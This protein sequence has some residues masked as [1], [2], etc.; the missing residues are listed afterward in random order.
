MC[1]RE[2]FILYYY[3]IENHAEIV[4]MYPGSSSGG[5]DDVDYR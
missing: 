3:M 1:F 2:V 4:Q 5:D